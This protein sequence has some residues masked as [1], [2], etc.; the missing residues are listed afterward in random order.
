VY[1]D[2]LKKEL[3]S[4][5]IKYSV[6]DESIVRFLDGNEQKFKTIL[7]K[8][9]KM[10]HLG[11]ATSFPDGRRKKRL[12][13]LLKEEGVEHVVLTQKNGV[14]IRWYSDDDGQRKR[15]WNKINALDGR[16]ERAWD[17]LHGW[18]CSRKRKDKTTDS[19]TSKPSVS[20]KLTPKKDVNKPC[21]S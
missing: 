8:I 1:L 10:Y 12:V 6:D 3:D 16:K 20:S 9:H 18:D 13:S 2:A 5:G 7:L 11:D 14:M 15:I 21:A 19:K 4:A 17:K